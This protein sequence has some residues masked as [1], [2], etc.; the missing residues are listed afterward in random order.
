[1]TLDQFRYAAVAEFERAKISQYQVFASART[2]GLACALFD[3]EYDD[4]WSVAGTNDTVRGARR[5][6]ALEDLRSILARKRLTKP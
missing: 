1:M 6:R 2:E 4:S 5:R 3:F